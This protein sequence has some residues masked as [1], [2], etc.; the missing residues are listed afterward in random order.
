MKSYG[1]FAMMIVTSTVIMF[2]LMYL[3]TYALDHVFFS[4]TRLYMALLMGA[5]MAMIMMAFMWKMYANKKLNVGI[6]GVSVIVF[7]LSLYLVRSQATI[8]DTSWMK[9]MIPHHSIAIL[10]SE[11]AKLS[12]PRVKDLADKI[13]EAQKKE[14]KEMKVLIEELEQRE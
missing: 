8:E 14:I 11:R 1:R 5:T 10:T 9:A 4:E 12:D 7:A 3:N 13:I 6:L 2:G